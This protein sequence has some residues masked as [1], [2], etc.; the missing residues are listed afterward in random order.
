MKEGWQSAGERVVSE[1]Y[2]LLGKRDGMLLKI[3]CYSGILEN[4]F[5]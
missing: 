4:T 1:S 3:I 2:A 5:A